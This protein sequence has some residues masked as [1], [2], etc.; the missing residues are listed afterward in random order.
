M[1]N[2]NYIYNIEGFGIKSYPNGHKCKKNS[3]CASSYC[4]PKGKCRWH[5]SSDYIPVVFIANAITAK[6]RAEADKQQHKKHDEK[7][8]KST[9]DPTMTNQNNNGNNNE[10]KIYEEDDNNEYEEDTK[11]ESN[12]DD[13]E[14]SGL[15]VYAIVLIAIACLLFFILII[16]LFIKYFSK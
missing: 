7:A 16:Y 3:D 1:D 14:N 10:N 2:L 9:T 4:H 5:G 12:D 6:D 8:A 11:K 13:G 15:P